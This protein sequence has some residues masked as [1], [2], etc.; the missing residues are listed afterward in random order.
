MATL[1]L[2]LSNHQRRDPVPLP[3]L[4]R[5]ARRAVDALRIRRRGALCVAFIDSRTMRALNKRFTHH[6]GLTDV[7]SFNYAEDA[8]VGEIL[9]S[10][11]FARQYATQHRLSYRQELARYVAHGLLHWLGHDDRTPREQSAMRRREDRL[12]TACLPKAAR[13]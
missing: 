11:A 3:W 5:F 8:I 2:Q 1:T 4:A 9:V 6:T 7:L 10:P 12:L 13:R